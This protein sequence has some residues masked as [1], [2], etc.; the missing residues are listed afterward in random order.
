MKRV[1]TGAQPE[2]HVEVERLE[3]RDEELPFAQVM[4]LEWEPV[5]KQA[6]RPLVPDIAAAHLAL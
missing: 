5:D 4:G 1:R 3:E 2:R 6:A